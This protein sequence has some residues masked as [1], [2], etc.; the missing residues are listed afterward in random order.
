MSSSSL[1][2]ITLL[3]EAP[4]GRRG[5]QHLVNRV[6][7][8]DRVGG[9]GWEEGQGGRGWVGGGTGWEG[10]GRRRDRVGGAG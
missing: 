3:A 9:A 7:G 1:Q 6:S 2:A 5:L 4:E 8:Q 10:L